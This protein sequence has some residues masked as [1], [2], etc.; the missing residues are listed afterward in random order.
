M[1]PTIHTPRKEDTKHDAVRRNFTIII[2]IAFLASIQMVAL[3]TFIEV[4]VL[5]KKWSLRT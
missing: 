1:H 5:Y 2:L 3:F 4:A